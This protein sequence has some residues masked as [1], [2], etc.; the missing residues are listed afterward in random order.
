MN[1]EVHLNIVA[2][3]IVCGLH[4]A[5]LYSQEAQLPTP[6]TLSSGW[7]DTLLNEEEGKTEE[8]LVAFSRL[9]QGVARQVPPDRR[10]EIQ[11]LLD[12]AQA[13][14]QRFLELQE[15]QG[16][17][18]S[19]PPASREM[20][21]VE[22]LL[23]VASKQR[24]L[25]RE[26]SIAKGDL[27]RLEKTL[28]RIL[29]QIDSLYSQYGGSELQS[30]QRTELGLNLIVAVT[31]R[32]I[33]NQKI[34]LTSERLANSERRLGW[35]QQEVLNASRRL[36]P[37]TI[38]TKKLTSQIEE[39]KKEQNEFQQELLR[40]ETEVE[41]LEGQSL[42]I[43]R[44][45]VN[46]SRSLTSIVEIQARQALLDLLNES[47]TSTQAQKWVKDASSW[48]TELK[49]LK[50]LADEWAGTLLTEE[51]LLERLTGEQGELVQDTLSDIK[52]LDNRIYRANT[53][54]GVIL[55]KGIQ[56]LDWWSGLWKRAYLWLIHSF[57]TLLWVLTYPL[58][59]M[60]DQPVNLIRI[61]SAFLIFFLAYLGS[62]TLRS[63][64]T[65][66][67]RRREHISN[68]S[69][70]AFNR[71]AHYVILSI[72]LVFAL[73]FVG[74][75]FSK[76]L[77][78]AGALSVGIGF[79][80]Q[81]IVNNFLGGLIVLFDRK[82]RI[83][84]LVELGAGVMGHITEV[85]VQNTVIRTLTGHDVLV[86][87]SDM[88]TRQ[89]TNWTLRDQF[90]RFHIPFGVAYGSDKAVVKSAIE[91][92]AR[93]IEETVTDHKTVANPSVWLVGFGDN[94]LNFE[95]VVW[96]DFKKSRKRE[97]SLRAAYFWEIETALKEHDIEIPFPQRDLHIRSGGFSMNEGEIRV[98]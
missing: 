23:N 94:S 40:K 11:G 91:S 29:H 69:I 54:V 59:W 17:S 49:D 60:N 2:F 79:G 38:D 82:I 22:E 30:L 15:T 41:A 97:S 25:E 88:I 28:E 52:D 19:D 90:A 95:L 1:M 26:I 48:K 10:E 9:I 5:V 4:S 34:R 53:L 58:M 86:P 81:G 76:L 64:F 63:V 62:K 46:V 66:Y 68:A 92:A 55:V 31:H 44:A 80:L 85:N 70:Y 47:K 37:E 6:E 89:L 74:I 16:Y 93:N 43:I 12:R 42:D 7:W 24:N 51:R 65:Q 61:A 35:V 75:N 87:N 3:L 71:V 96:V 21:T 20:Y 13:N 36:S 73:S 77:I 72:G 39:A 45:R 18:L 32:A 57:D 98:D 84:D 8:R 83:G 56:E 14:I 78:I 67:V 27:A 33:L 50:A